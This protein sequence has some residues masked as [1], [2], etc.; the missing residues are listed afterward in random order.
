M[1]K[2]SCRKSQFTLIELLV[3]VAII[4]IL[5][6]LLLPAL[7]RARDK[8]RAALCMGNLKQ[9]GLAT[10][11][12][13]SDYNGLTQE[14]RPVGVSYPDNYWPVLMGEL[15]YLPVGVKKKSHVTICPSVNPYSWSF[16]ARGYSMRGA[17]EGPVARSTHF[18]PSGTLLVDT[19]NVSRSLSSKTYNLA[20][21]EF[22][23]FFDSFAQTGTN[24]YSSHCFTNPDSAGLN[25]SEKA[26]I[27]FADGHTDLSN[28]RHGYL[29]YGRI[30][31]N[32]LA[33]VKL[34][35]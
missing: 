11:L 22:L 29:S 23:L 2:A 7:S 13:A 21:D 25:H 16:Q 1:K 17:L 3:V 19:G 12:Y 27:V 24:Y 14:G 9:V 4:S 20:P 6:S 18:Q 5:A 32:Y 26:A 35:N 34:N 33:K 30:G 31:G 10:E 15:G 28:R 8:A